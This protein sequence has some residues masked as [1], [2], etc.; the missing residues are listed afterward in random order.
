MLQVPR[1]KLLK[2]AQMS[3]KNNTLLSIYTGLSKL[4]SA[5]LNEPWSQCYLSFTGKSSNKPAL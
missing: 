3:T 4:W 2:I 1:I 5:A